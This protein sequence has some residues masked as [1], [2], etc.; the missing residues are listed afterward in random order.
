MAECSSGKYGKSSEASC[1]FLRA[2]ARS[3]CSERPSARSPTMTRWHWA[4]ALPDDKKRCAEWELGSLSEPLPCLDRF[5]FPYCP[6]ESRRRQPLRRRGRQL[7]AA[8]VALHLE[9]HALAAHLHGG[10]TLDWVIQGQTRGTHYMTVFNGNGK[11]LPRPA[12][13]FD[14]EN[15]KYAQAQATLQPRSSLCPG[16]R[17]S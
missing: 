6:V 12:P 11:R 4:S 2:A 14:L 9:L 16:A 17:A 10:R 8:R 7:V 5:E 1:T 13:G 3:S 15:A